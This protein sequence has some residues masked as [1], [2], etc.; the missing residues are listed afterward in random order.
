MRTELQCFEPNPYRRLAI[1]SITKGVDIEYAKHWDAIR[2]SWLVTG[3]FIYNIDRALSRLYINLK[4]DEHWTAPEF[5]DD[6][7]LNNPEESDELYRCIDK[8]LLSR[9]FC[10]KRIERKL[11]ARGK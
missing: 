6:E 3:T 1:L 11:K 7:C 5:V 9:L 10:L 4:K 2:A 8:A